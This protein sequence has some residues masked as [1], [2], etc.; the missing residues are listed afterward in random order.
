MVCRRM[1]ANRWGSVDRL[2]FFPRF[3][4]NRFSRRDVDFGASAGIASDAGLARPYVEH[5]ESPQLDAFALGE[6]ALHAFKDR[7]NRGFGFRFGDAGAIDDF[8][9]DVEFDHALLP[10]T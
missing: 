4:P 6:G 5:A 2:Q 8:V 10:G 1:I 9:D 3:E 7:F